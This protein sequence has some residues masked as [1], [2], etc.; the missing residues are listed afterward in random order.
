MTVEGI[1]S[2]RKRAAPEALWRIT[3]ISILIASRF[4]AVST[5][6][7]PFATDDPDVEMLTVSALSLFSANSNDTRVRVDASKKKI[8]DCLSSE[9]RNLLDA[10]LGDFLE[11]F[12]SVE[13]LENLIGGKLL[14]PNQVLS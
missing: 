6:V 7:S 2:A 1:R 10:T 11:R 3:T 14:K 8:D 4:R 12:R 9:D 5:N 13:Y